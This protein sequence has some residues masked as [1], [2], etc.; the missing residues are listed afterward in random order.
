MDLFSSALPFKYC[1]KKLIAG[2]TFCCC[3]LL[4]L[5][6]FAQRSVSAFSAFQKQA[7]QVTIVRDNWGVP[8][9]YGKTDA[10]AV[11][12]LLYAMCE[13]NYWQ[14]EE[15]FV[16][17]T[18]QMAK[19]YG[20]AALQN[21]INVKLFN[22]ESI[23]K[24]NYDNAS[25]KIKAI[26]NSAAAGVNYFLY[27]NPKT[28]QRL[29][30]H[31]EP[32]MWFISEYPTLSQLGID[33][34]F[35]PVSSQISSQ[36]SEGEFEA[37]WMEKLEHGSNSIAIGPA[38]SS[39]GNCLLLINPHVNFFGDNQRYEAHLIS[40]A[41]L[42]VSGFA[43]LGSA[44]L[45]S[46]FNENLGWSHTNSAADKEDAW[47]E[48][49]DDTTNALHYKYEGNYQTATERIDTIYVKDS[50]GRI[51]PHAY[52]FLQTI[53]GPVIAQK[54][55]I[56]VAC[57]STE[58][59]AN[60]L[61]L[62]CWKMM[63]SKNTTDFEQAMNMR[64]LGYPT[65]TYADRFGNISYWHGN[66]IPKRNNS[67]NWKKPI[68]GSIATTQWQG[69]HALN[70]IVQIKNPISGFI[71]NTNATPFL[72][73]GLPVIDSLLYPF[74]MAPEGQNFRAIEALEQLSKPG[75]LTAEKLRQLSTS[76]HIAMMQNWLPQMLKGIDSLQAIQPLTNAHVIVAL[77]TLRQWHYNYDSSSTATTIAVAWY[78]SAMQL[79]RAVIS[80]YTA[81]LGRTQNPVMLPL[82]ALQD[83]AVLTAAVEDLVAVYGTPLVAWGSI[84][85]LQRIHSS[86]KTEPFSDSRSS[87]S[88]SAVPGNMGSLFAF[89]AREEKGQRNLYGTYGNSYVCI[90]EFPKN[91]QQKLQAKSIVYFGQTANPSSPHYFDQAPLYAKGQLKAA[92]FYK[93]DVLAHA[94]RKYHPGD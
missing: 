2:L 42:N 75:K 87:V 18:G 40:D 45:W 9:I 90:V 28:I 58:L 77:D 17:Y 1:S 47:L 22:L 66:A 13:D 31:Y 64:Q 46:G 43:F 36:K 15:D 92:W 52:T 21:D 32:W 60:H 37:D 6:V 19:L 24:K 7:K 11:F 83:L 44:F 86:G 10:D 56:K 48:I 67:L 27:K 57:N 49:F 76:P 16:K 5:T 54:N 85:R 59:M 23:A 71:Y 79:Y 8:H 55:Q 25:V 50:L 82:S 65:T 14:L 94:E 68:D 51:V 33:K 69:L 41:G 88:V 35:I 4:S 34:S 53:H 29:I 70:E 78:L 80:N 20:A 38:K 61:L 3:M 72:A 74:Y 26:A 84:N 93:A 91:K 89:N 39:T 63:K 12:G 30:H 73:K 62:Q 81:A